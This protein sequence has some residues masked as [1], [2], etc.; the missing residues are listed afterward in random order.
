MKYKSLLLF[1][2]IGGIVGLIFH[3]IW[4]NILGISLLTFASHIALGIIHTLI[5]AVIGALTGFLIKRKQ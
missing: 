4:H 3:L 5:G 2:W 1:T